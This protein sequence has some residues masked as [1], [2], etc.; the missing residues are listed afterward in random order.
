MQRTRTT[1]LL[2]SLFGLIAVAL[3]A[4]GGLSVPA[5]AAPVSTLTGF[6]PA[7]THSDSVDF[8]LI[9]APPG[10]APSRS[11]VIF[12]HDTTQLTAG[13]DTEFISGG[14]AS[15]TLSTAG[16]VFIDDWPLGAQ[17]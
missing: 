1:S 16:H 8:G 12:V 14:L 3:V 10:N 5:M 9:A 6:V 15:S 17:N 7:L 4:V 11:S 2:S 13:A